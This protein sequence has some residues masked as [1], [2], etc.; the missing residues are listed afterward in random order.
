MFVNKAKLHVLLKE[1]I[2]W[3]IFHKQITI[4]L[5]PTKS[6][7]TVLQTKQGKIF[8]LCEYKLCLL[9]TPVDNYPS[10]RDLELPPP[11]GGEGGFLKIKKYF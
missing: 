10:F 3:M 6:V 1:L 4:V 7:T 11:G 5:A 2:L 8:F 9:D